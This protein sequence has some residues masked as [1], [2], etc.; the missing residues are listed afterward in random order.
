M[1]P[2]ASYLAHA[3]HWGLGL[4]L[5]LLTAACEQGLAPPDAPPTGRLVGTI[6][7]DVAS[8]P[9]RDSVRDLRFVALPF[10]PRDTSDL[11]RDLDQLV[12]SEPLAYGV[13]RDTFTIDG[14]PA[15]T[16]VYGGV[17]QQ[18]S[19][20]VLDWRPVGLVEQNGGIILV[21]DGLTTIV[22]V[23]VDFANPPPFPPQQP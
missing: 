3:L 4:C 11:F 9:P 10:V 15:G 12:I 20:D 23:S 19:P 21:R 7:Y 22:R 16:Y 13:P 17:A 6:T 1:P 14:V 2:T 8:W 18:Y 5:V